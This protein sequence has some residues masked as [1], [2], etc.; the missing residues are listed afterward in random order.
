MSI[1]ERQ[2][3]PHR[4]F[5]GGEPAPRP[6]T[7]PRLRAL[8]PYAIVPL[9]I[10][11]AV[12]ARSTSGSFGYDTVVYVSGSLLIGLLMLRQVITS[13]ENRRLYDRLGAAY[14]TQGHGLARR[15]AELEWLRDVSR[16]VNTARTLVEVLDVTYEG[17]RALGFDR[18]GINL[19]D[20]EAGTFEDWIGTDES[21]RKT[22]SHNRMFQLTPDSAIWR[23]P[24][25]AAAL[26]GEDLYYSTE[27]YA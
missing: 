25:F 4:F 20:S 13:A 18:V 24:G 21:G 10:A 8:L 2:D 16:Q 6:A 5:T 7:P 14:T 22:W 26:R 19:F 15:V 3:Q 27:A 9:A 1:D 23:F 11:L 12:A 17:C